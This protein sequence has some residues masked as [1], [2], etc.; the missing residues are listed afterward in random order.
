M[1][2]AGADALSG[3]QDSGISTRKDILVMVSLI[4]RSSN[5]RLNKVD[6]M[7][8]YE[9]DRL[10]SRHRTAHALALSRVTSHVIETGPPAERPKSA[11]DQHHD[12]E[13]D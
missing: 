12:D 10:A 6:A 13:H 3:S 8:V 5:A 1:S 4:M 9:I 11:K 7:N 2:D